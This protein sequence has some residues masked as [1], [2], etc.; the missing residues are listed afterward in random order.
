MPI[1]PELLKRLETTRH[2]AEQGGG[3]DKIKKRHEKGLMTARERLI[4]LFEPG[5]F[6]EFGQ[7]A[8]H[9]CHQFGMASKSM[10]GDGV[11]TGVGQPAVLQGSA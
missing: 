6:M 4:A 11:V 5:T 3:A 9:S 10:P 7:M 1:A 2:A 8:Q